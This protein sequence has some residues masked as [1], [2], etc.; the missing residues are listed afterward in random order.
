VGSGSVGRNGPPYYL[1]KNQFALAVSMKRTDD[2]DGV[3]KFGVFFSAVPKMNAPK[4]FQ[5]FDYFL[6]VLN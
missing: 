3:N 6:V 5:P 4:R 2:W 1:V